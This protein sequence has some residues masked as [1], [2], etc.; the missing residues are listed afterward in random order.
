M[1][2]HAWKQF[3]LTT[4][5]GL[6][7]VGRVSA[8]FTM[9][10]DIPYDAITGVDPNLLS[11]DIYTPDGADGT[12]PVMIMY[13]GGAF[14]SGDKTVDGVVHPKME[15][16]TSL[17]WVFL[18]VN[19]RLTDVTLPVDH[20]DQVVHPEHIKNVARSIAW[21]FEN[22]SAYGG[23]PQRIV[24]MGFSAGAT[25]VALAATD[26]SR[27]VAEGCQLNYLDGIVALD[28]IY[29]IPLRSQQLPPPPPELELVWSG[30]LLVQ[31]DLS[32]TWHVTAG[33][34]IP[35]MLIVHS[36]GPINT[37]QSNL[38]VDTLASSGFNVKE[39]NATGLTHP[40]T[41]ASP[42]IEGHP[43]TIEIDAFLNSLTSNA[44]ACPAA[45]V[46]AVS[47]W[48]LAVIAM[49]MLCTG[50]VVFRVRF[51]HKLRSKSI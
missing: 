6:L 31:Q 1:S 46:P 49:L 48:S 50:T 22:I 42:G 34:C 28:G 14:N 17:G 41:G 23:D 37:A 36:D 32:P 7:L 9:F 25:L 27:L 15:Y 39:Y 16:Y 30:S 19:Y 33:S 3:F 26:E 13:H 29:D 43:L 40:Q 8:Q 35:P 20:P 44:A 12:N 47:T 21:T 2:C 10:A 18:S 38:F 45:T 5:T 11:L 4:I 24:L 51:D